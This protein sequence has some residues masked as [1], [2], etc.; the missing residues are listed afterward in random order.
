MSPMYFRPSDAGRYTCVATNNVG[1]DEKDTD[2]VVNVP[3]TIDGDNYVPEIVRQAE[4]SSFTLQV[5]LF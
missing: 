5:S 1:S 3:P 2:V 4:N